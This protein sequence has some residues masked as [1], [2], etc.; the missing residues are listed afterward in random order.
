MSDF[1]RG[2]ATAAER[3]RSN[4]PNGRGDI[5][6]QARCAPSVGEARRWRALTQ[7]NNRWNCRWSTS[8][9]NQRTWLNCVLPKQARLKRNRRARVR[10]TINKVNA[11]W[12]R[13]N[14]AFPDRGRALGV[15]VMEGST[16]D[17]SCG[18][19]ACNWR[20]ALCMTANPP[21]NPNR[22]DRTGEGSRFQQVNLG[23]RRCVKRVEFCV[24]LAEESMLLDVCV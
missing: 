4:E 20:A 6:A 10:T 1:G 18:L 3:A 7:D 14:R 15:N 13:Q 5:V 12:R 23:N 24:I 8:D 21:I 22:C 16:T 2:C 9:P 19:G 17:C 11:S